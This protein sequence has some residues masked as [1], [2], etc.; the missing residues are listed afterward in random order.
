M[1][2]LNFDRLNELDAKAF[3][4]TMPFPWINPAGLLTDEGYR[5]L[6]ET[7]PDVSLFDESFGVK[8]SHGQRAHDRFVLEYDDNLD[9]AQPWKDFVAE[10]RGGAYRNFIARMMGSD[11]FTMNCHWHY[12]SAG[13]SVSPHC[14]AKRK[15]GSHVFYFNTEKDWD[16]A[17]GGQTLVLDDGERLISDAHP[18]E[19][20]LKLVAASQAM[21]NYSLLFKRGEHSWHSVTE[22]TCSEGY[23]RK[24]FILVI[25]RVTRKGWLRRLFGDLPKS[26]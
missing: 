11:R 14:D 15:H 7:L 25:N 26:M 5:R 1:T 16:S 4:A 9:V 17:W 6:V 21:G 19:E 13:C 3:Q 22:L 24:V 12:A 8:R 10:L 2:Y 18:E 23:L 20:D